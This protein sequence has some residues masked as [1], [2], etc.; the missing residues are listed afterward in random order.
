MRAS[1]ARSVEAVSDSPHQASRAGN[2]G[3]LFHHGCKP[4]DCPGAK[5]VAV[6]EAAGKDHA[7]RPLE[8]RVLVP[9]VLQL[10][11]QHL[12]DDPAAIA[13]GP[14]TRKYDD[15]EFHLCFSPS[16]TIS[17]RKSSITWLASSCR[18]IASTR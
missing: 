15:A 4:S 16:G 9:Q 14:R 11:A 13:V 5:V 1:H 12:V 2:V 6:G 7:V 18:H 3:D 8:V 10:M 17:N